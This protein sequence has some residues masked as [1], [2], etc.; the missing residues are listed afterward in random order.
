MKAG[1]TESSK[2]GMT[3]NVKMPTDVLFLNII[4][5]TPACCHG[6][7]YIVFDIRFEHLNQFSIQIDSLCSHPEEGSQKEV[8]H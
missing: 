6:N 3:Y 8:L 7:S 1:T 5:L 2:Y 4:H